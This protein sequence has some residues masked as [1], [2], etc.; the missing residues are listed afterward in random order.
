MFFF[1]EREGLKVVSSGGFRCVF[2]MF[3]VWWTFSILEGKA[4]HEA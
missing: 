3:F 2:W 1:A 4:H